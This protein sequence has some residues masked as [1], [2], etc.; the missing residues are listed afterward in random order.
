MWLHIYYIC[1]VGI[2]ILVYQCTT[3]KTAIKAHCIYV[4]V[5]LLDLGRLLTAGVETVFGI[6][7]YIIL[8][9][10]SHLGGGYT[11]L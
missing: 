1:D 8:L 5:M 6:Y 9:N 4:R 10:I 2:T 11:S 7:W 3:I